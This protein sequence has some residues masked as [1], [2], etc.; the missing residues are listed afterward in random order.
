MTV[1]S[2]RRILGL[3]PFAPFDL[4]QLRTAYFESAKKTH[5]DTKEQQPVIVAVYRIQ[6]Y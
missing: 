6:G 4:T 3:S 5:P 2:A 1:S